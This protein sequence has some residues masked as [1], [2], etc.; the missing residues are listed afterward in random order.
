MNMFRFF[1]KTFLLISIL[2][3]GIILGFL[4]ANN[5]LHKMKG[6]DDGSF[7]RV[8]SIEEHEGAYVTSILGEKISSHNLNEKKKIIEEIHT[9]NIF[10][11][12][13]QK[14]AHFFNTIFSSVFL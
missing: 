5:G 8:I 7:E 12:I 14:L 6:Y 10:S 1:L 11:D 4:E 2:F 3:F 13:A 9:Y